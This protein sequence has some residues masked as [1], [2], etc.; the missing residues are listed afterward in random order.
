MAC[1]VCSAVIH[2]RCQNAYLA[3]LH[4]N[5]KVPRMDIQ[6]VKAEVLNPDHHWFCTRTCLD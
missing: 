2:F 5:E 1:T 3:T 4:A 6:E